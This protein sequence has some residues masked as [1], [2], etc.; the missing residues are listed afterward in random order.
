MKTITPTIKAT[1]EEGKIKCD[2]QGFGK[3]IVRMWA[4]LT[5]YICGVMKMTL[6]D[7]ELAAALMEDEE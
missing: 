4:Y 5:A 1:K 7:L 2:A 3:D 6:K